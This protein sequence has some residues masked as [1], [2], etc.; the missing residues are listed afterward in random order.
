[1]KHFKNKM[2]DFALLF[3][4]QM[5]SWPVIFFSNSANFLL[6]FYDPTPFLILFT[7][8]SSKIFTILALNFCLLNV[9]STATFQLVVLLK[10]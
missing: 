3:I 7:E 2:P 5:V 6:F 9:F 4:E 8:I 10:S 1:M